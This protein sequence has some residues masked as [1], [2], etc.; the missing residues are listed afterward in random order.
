MGVIIPEGFYQAAYSF[1]VQ[2]AVKDTVT[3]LGGSSLDLGS[4]TAEEIADVLYGIVSTSG[5]VF[6]ANAM[7][8][9]WTFQGVTVTL[10]TGTGPIVA[11][12]IEP[13]VGTISA[14]N[15]PS[16]CC[17]LVKKNTAAGGRKNRGRMY[18]PAAV[19]GESSVDAAGF[20]GTGVQAAY[21]TQWDAF[22][23]ALDAD[24]QVP[25]LLHSDATAP[26]E[27]TSFSV[28]SQ[29]ATQRRRLR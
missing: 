18:V 7:T 26:T 28:E 15:P 1:T 10:M 6:A 9:K 23:S 21:Q 8:N 5:N 11:S 20:L 16:N 17:I 13:Y 29:I 24:D 14:D 3:T 2:G 19:M 4:Q 25:A 12:H 27:I 22:K